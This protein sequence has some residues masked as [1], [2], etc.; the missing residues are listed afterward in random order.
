MNLPVAQFKTLA[1]HD[2]YSITWPVRRKLSNCVLT[3]ESRCIATRPVRATSR[4]PYSFKRLCAAIILPCRRQMHT[5]YSSFD[6]GHIEPTCS[7]PP[8]RAA[9]QDSCGTKDCKGL[10]VYLF[11]L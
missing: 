6:L 10:Q 9:S 2:A 1:P 3:P 8:Q 5:L 7:L 11:A 4:I